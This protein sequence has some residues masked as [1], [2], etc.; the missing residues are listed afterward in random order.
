MTGDI[1]QAD[2]VFSPPQFRKHSLVCVAVVNAGKGWM[3]TQ[4][5]D[6]IDFATFVME[7]LA[8]D[9]CATQHADPLLYEPV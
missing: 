2:I 3:L 6:K 7:L 8:R 5:N 9:A 1:I 4:R